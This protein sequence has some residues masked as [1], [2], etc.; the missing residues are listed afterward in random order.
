MFYEYHE[1]LRAEAIAAYPNE[2]VWLITPGECR[3]VKNV[4]TEPTLTFRVG[5]RAMASAMQRGLL[6]IAHSHP[7]FPACPSA[8]DMRGQISSGVP[9]GIVSTDGETAAEPIWWGEGIERPPLIGRGFRHGIADCYSLIRDYYLLE[10]GIDLPEFPRDW[11][12][13]H[14]G[15]D[16]YRDGFKKAGF[17]VIEAS[18][19]KAGDVWLAQLRSKVP[20]HGGVL[21]DG[22]L[23]LHHP[24]TTNAVDASRISRREPLARWQHHITHWL[25]HEA[26]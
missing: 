26:L 19:A 25:R 13:W 15:E 14:K 16:L 11:E 12:W 4:S 17:R 3:R 7:D 22:G 18:E 23:G 20:S 10:L 5:K 21:L 9:W 6:A 2:A 8:A 24:S 1:Q